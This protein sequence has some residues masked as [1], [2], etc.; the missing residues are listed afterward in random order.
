MNKNSESGSFSGKI[1]DYFS[2]TNGV[3]DLFYM[4]RNL[5]GNIVTPIAERKH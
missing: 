4:D 5:I 1:S 2:N 3:N